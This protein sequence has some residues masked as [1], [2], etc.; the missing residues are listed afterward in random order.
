MKHKFDVFVKAIPIFFAAFVLLSSFTLLVCAENEMTPGTV[1][2]NNSTMT[3][4]RTL[5]RGDSGTSLQP[6]VTETGKISLSV[7]GLGTDSSGIIQVEKPEGATVRSAYL[8]AAGE[9]GSQIPEGSVLINGSAVYWNNTVFSTACYNYW[10]DVTSIVKPAVDIAPAGRV[11]FTVT[12]TSPYSSDGE[13]LAVIFDDPDQKEDNTVILLFGG[14]NPAGDTFS[15]KLSDPVDKNDSNFAIDMGLGISFSYQNSG[16]SQVSNVNVN[17]VRVTSSAGGEDDGFSGNGALLTVGGLDDSTANPLDPYAGPSNPRTDDELYNL[18]P[19]VNSGDSNITVFTQN[20]SN[21]DNIFFSYFFLKSSTAMVGE[22]ILLS[23]ASG[24]ASVGSQYTLSSLVQDDNGNLLAGK[25]VSFSVVSGPNAGQSGTSITDAAGR[26]N[27]TCSGASTGTDIIEASF[28][29]NAGE[30]IVSNRASIEWIVPHV[31]SPAADFNSNVTLGVQPLTVEFYD[32]SE[33]AVSWNWYFGDGNSS[34]LQNCTCTYFDPGYY[35]VSLTVNN[36]AGSSNT[37]IREDYIFVQMRPVPGF[38]ANVT[39]GT[40]PL[41][42]QF[43]DES[44]YTESVEWDF[45]D[46]NTSNELN[47]VHTYSEAG[48]YSVSLIA[49][50]N[51]TSVTKTIDNYINVTTSPV[52]DFSSNIT[53]GTVPLSVQF[54]DESQYAESVEWDFGDGDSSTDRNPAH[55]YSESGL[56]T[57]SL[58][59]IGNRTSVV[60]TVNDFINVTIPPLPNFSV[61]IIEGTFPL[62]VQFSDNSSY[63]E[64]VEWDFGDGDSST[65]RNPVHTY[66]EAG[67]YSVSLIATGN[68]TSVTKTVD[69]FINVTAPPVP[70]FI[71]NVTEGTFPLTVQFTDNSRYAE[72]VIW[73]FGDGDSSFQRNPVHTFTASGLYTFSLTATGNNTSVTKIADDF[74]NVTVPPVP[75]F[76][77]NITEGLYPLS[78]QFT[79]NSSYAESLEWDFGDGNTSTDLSPLHTY[80]E[81][82]LYTVSLT[83][84]G[85]RTSVTRTAESYIN[86]ILPPIPDFGANVTTGPYPLTVQ[87]MDNSIYAESVVWDFGDGSVSNEKNPVHTYKERGLYTVT[88]GAGGNGTTVNKTVQDFINVTIQP[89]PPEANFSVNVTREPAPLTVSFLDESYNSVSWEWDI[90][91]DG[92]VDYI[93][94]NPV[95]TYET[96]G[97]YN[98]SLYV[99]NAYG[100]DTEVV[101]GCINVLTHPVISE[102]NLSKTSVY[103]GEEFNVNLNIE[104]AWELT[105]LT[106]VEDIPAGWNLTPIDNAGAEFNS[107]SNKWIWENYS[108]RDRRQLVYVLKA[109]LDSDFGTFKLEGD[110]LAENVVA[111]PVEGES[112]ITITPIADYS[113]ENLKLLHVGDPDQEFN[114][115]THVLCNFTWYVNGNESSE[116]DKKNSAY[117]S[118]TLSPETLWRNDHFKNSYTSVENSSL[119]A[120]KYSVTGRV[121]NRSTAINQTWN[122]LITRS[123][124]SKNNINNTVVLPVRNVEENESVSFNFTEEPDNTDDNSILAISFNASSTGNVSVFVEVLKDRASEVTKNPEGE[125]FQHINIHFS[126]HTVMNETGSDSKFID[127]KVNRTWME[128]VVQGTVRLNRYQNGEW[129]PLNTWETSSDAEYHYF[130]AETPG[131]SPFSVTAEKISTPSV[132]TPHKGG[133]GTGSATII[134]STKGE[135][136]SIF[137]VENEG[138]D[139]TLSKGAEDILVSQSTDTGKSIFVEEG[140]GS[141]AAGSEENNGS[142][143]SGSTGVLFFILLVLFIV[144]AYLVYRQTKEE[145]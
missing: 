91:G 22:G 12:E 131:F 53:A 32:L 58:T 134:S 21:D 97:I 79:D 140:N 121:S 126:N 33:N 11:N 125:V 108:A 112:E 18:L 118:L 85:N 46:G 69:D 10:A 38:I 47:P 141:E 74:I 94:A 43:T 9:W 7:D 110:V 86:V 66:S 130:R 128:T 29:T 100:N 99:S 62:A 42:V 8:I 39:E 116:G 50:G 89:F 41:T 31:P 87:F 137:G 120:G 123:A 143:K 136:E 71:T 114:I 133:S 3:I 88:L 52:P 90:D 17:G 122:F 104:S 73:D 83:A 111:I 6:M 14:Q 45:G 127:F 109:P 76:S 24:N 119:F 98:V 117:A 15:I 105:N 28:V 70:D 1:L 144:G 30:T 95:H 60:K 2:E 92:W 106:V 35:T 51:N 75:D 93:E 129:Q 56:Y 54:I 48:L 102:R 19:F 138:A 34:E 23:P 145:E 57:V 77:A 139:S 27:F 5:V 68:G 59:A 49:T 101:K 84:T 67:L 78:V 142:E 72:S 63:T 107:T 124:E 64:S 103:P 4:P 40:F 20:P 135:D 82:G 16:G 80:S 37:T 61:N 132:S 113:P 65:E 13:V 115:S 96:A 44:Q 26:A 81:A 25:P 36:L 55:T